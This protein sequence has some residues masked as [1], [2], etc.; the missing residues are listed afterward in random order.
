[1]RSITLKNLPDELVE[2]LKAR[3]ADS[4]RSLNGEILFRLGRSLESEAA[5]SGLREEPSVQADAWARL[6]GSWVSDVSVEEEIESLYAARSSGRD[7][8][9]SW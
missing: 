4:H 7:V 8:D 1:M 6:A 9:V 3:A 2:T 5:A